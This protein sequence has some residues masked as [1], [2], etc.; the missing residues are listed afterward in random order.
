MLKNYLKIAVRNLWKHKLFSLINVFG[1]ASGLTVCLLAI[2]HIRGAFTYDSFHSNRD[3]TYRILTDVV[4]QT[5][6]MHPYATSPMPL[7]E[8][9]KRDY[10]FVEAATRVVRT[11]GDVSGNGRVLSLITFAVDPGFFRLFSYPLAQGRP[12]TE[13]GTAVVTRQ[14]AERFFGT[15]DPIGKTL[16]QGDTGPMLITGVLAENPAPSHLRFDMLVSLAPSAQTKL[17]GVFYDWREYHNGY[18]Y[19]LLKP[20]TRPE[21]LDNV[22]PSLA[23]RVTQGLAFAH[24]KGYS[25]RTQALTRLSPSRQDLMFTT[26]EPQIGGLLAELGIG[27]ITLLMAGFNYINLTLARSLG[28]AREVGIRKVAGAL[29]WQ[30]QAQFMAESVVLALLALGLAVGM[31]ELVRPM[32]FVQQWMLGSMAWDAPLWAMCLG[33][34]IVAGLLAGLIPARVLSGFEPAQ[35]LRS[36]TGLRVLRGLS[37]RKSLIVT[38]FT[39]SLVAMITLMTLMRQMNYMATADYGF[40]RTNVLTIPLADLPADRLA[41]KVEQLAGVESVGVTSDLFGAHGD[42]RMARRQRNAPDSTPAFTFAV[43]RQFLQTLQLKLVAGT[44]PFSSVA[45]TSSHRVVINEEA[46]RKLRLGSPAE[47]VGQTFWFDGAE[48]QV[49]GVVKDFR[50]TSFAWAIMPLVLRHQPGGLRYLNVAV[51][52]GATDNVRAEVAQIW[53][54]LKPYDPFAGIWYDDHLRERHTHADD[55][56]FMGLLVGLAFS[57]ACLGLLGMVTYSTQTRTKEVGIR[58]VMGAEVGQI[59][60]LLSRGFVWLLLLAAAIALPLGFLA[61]HA[62][63]FHF[64]YHVSIGLETLGACFGVLLLLGSLTISFQTYRAALAD[65]VK[66]IQTD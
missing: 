45:D 38:Q 17:P 19:V 1:L 37:L 15:A 55:T 30:V 33:F 29:R 21:Q 5:N 9:L 54:A 59:V 49:A 23:R 6:D 16:Q 52:D 41:Q 4:S 60:W 40:R 46:V 48:L 24:E 18:T 58:K 64:A 53:K 66:S 7:A 36:Q 61:G 32:A 12:A 3:R 62:I 20:G 57:I 35:V 14:T 65:P 25:F 11:Y 39:I 50:F 56:D 31:L 8:V 2:A 47:A 51:A 13:P 22:L 10:P 44:D 42:T 34:S 63:L 26:Y 28:R 43:G 27:L